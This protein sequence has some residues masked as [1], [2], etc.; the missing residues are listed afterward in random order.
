MWLTFVLNTS[1]NRRIQ[2]KLTTVKF[3]HNVSHLFYLCCNSWVLTHVTFALQ[4]YHFRLYICRWRMCIHW[5]L[6]SPLVEMSSFP[7]NS[8]TEHTHSRLSTRLLVS[9]LFNNISVHNCSFFTHHPRCTCIRMLCT[10]W[11]SIQIC[12]RLTICNR[13]AMSYRRLACSSAWSACCILH[14]VSKQLNTLASMRRLYFIVF[15]TSIRCTQSLT[16]K[17]T[18]KI[19]TLK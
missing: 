7:L 6:M 4:K 2:L 10:S 17:S 14:Y 13:A 1:F 16:S 3:T 15:F 19:G 18:V 8:I 11:G 9:V 5:W 12:L